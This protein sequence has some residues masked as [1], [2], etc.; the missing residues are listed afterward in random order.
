MAT[1]PSAWPKQNIKSVVVNN[2]FFLDQGQ[3]RFGG[4]SSERNHCRWILLRGKTLQW[5]FHHLG[6]LLQPLE[7]VP[8]SRKSAVPTE[9]QIRTILGDCIS[10]ARVISIQA[11]QLISDFLDLATLSIRD[12]AALASNWIKDRLEGLKLQNLALVTLTG[13]AMSSLQKKIT[14]DVQ[15]SVNKC[16]SLGSGKQLVLHG[17]PSVIARDFSPHMAVRRRHV[18]PNVQFEC[19]MILQGTLGGN[20]DIFAASGE[21][22]AWVLL[23]KTRSRPNGVSVC[24]V[25]QFNSFKTAF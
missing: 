12:D 4:I 1:V 10:N 13:P 6:N 21:S 7:F 11:P 23:W 2:L 19:C 22:T 16:K 24:L 20:F 15:H 14:A 18:L 3:A 5:I 9:W 17:N 8:D 25:A